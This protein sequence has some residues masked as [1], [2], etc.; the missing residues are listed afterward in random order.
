MLGTSLVPALIAAGHEVTATDIDE[1]DVRNPAD[2]THHVG[3]TRAEMVIHLAALTDLEDC[4]LN[5]ADTYETN[6]LGTKYIALACQDYDIPMAYVSTA[7]VFDGLKLGAYHEYDQ[8]N[9]INTYGR[10]K[11]AGEQYV[12]WFLNR[13]FI[14]RAGWM[15]GGHE[16]DHKFVSYIRK[17]IDEGATRIYAVDDRLGTP[18]Y[19]PDFSR[20]FTDLIATKSYGLYH[21][22][23]EGKATR[24]EVAA[25]ILKAL[26]R[27]DIELVGVRSSHFAE[28]FW[29]PRPRSEV[30]QNLLLNLQGWNT[31]RPWRQAIQE[32]VR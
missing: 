4:E 24:L 17:Q 16:R 29:A 8:P 19:A 23:C 30:M 28:R 21:M 6:A 5:P 14:V 15:V 27:E 25:E 32:Y 31:M 7:G 2:I 18:T 13:F 9:P 3:V 11:L 10:A 26:G 22:A 20:C 1:L 12:Q